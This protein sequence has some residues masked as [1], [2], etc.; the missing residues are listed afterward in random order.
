M[1]RFRLTPTIN[2]TDWT[3]SANEVT[4]NWDTWYNFRTKHPVQGSYEIYL[5]DLLIKSDSHI[6]N[7][8]WLPSSL[9]VSLSQLSPGEH[10]VTAIIVDAAG[11]S[12]TSA[13]TI[14]ITTV[15][16]RIW[17][18]STILKLAVTEWEFPAA[19]LSF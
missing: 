16:Y 18:G 13:V 11:N 10:N 8:W 14:H 9:T 3:I 7:K 5:D 17:N 15:L 4:V 6:F 1:E 19:Q 12:V 2:L